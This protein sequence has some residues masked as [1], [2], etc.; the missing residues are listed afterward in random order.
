MLRAPAQARSSLRGRQ[1]E[2]KQRAG[3]KGKRVCEVRS[4][5]TVRRTL[6]PMEL[7]VS[8]EEVF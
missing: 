6:V 1:E 2:G 4:Q 7:R 8:L 5:Q 3:E